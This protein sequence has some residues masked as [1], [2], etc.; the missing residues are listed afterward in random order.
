MRKNCHSGKWHISRQVGMGL[1]ATGDQILCLPGYSVQLKGRWFYSD[2]A[3]EALR[4][5]AEAWPKVAGNAARSRFQVLGGF[6]PG[7]TQSEVQ[8]LAVRKR[9]QGR[10]MYFLND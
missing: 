5:Y 10:F 3:V 9:V 7:E 4:A 8:T 1:Q 6:A 2:E